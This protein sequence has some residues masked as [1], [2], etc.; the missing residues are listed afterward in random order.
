VTLREECLGKDSELEPAHA[1]L[2]QILPEA[3]FALGLSYEFGQGVA[4][5][6]R[7]HPDQ[8]IN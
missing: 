8:Y 6:R 7:Y 1:H 5:N 4:R 2:Q 3:Q